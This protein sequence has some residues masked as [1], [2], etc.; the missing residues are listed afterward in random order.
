MKLMAGLHSPPR[1]LMD[2]LSRTGTLRLGIG[3]SVAVIRLLPLSVVDD[4]RGA[5]R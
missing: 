4:N 2:R 5:S 3:L 1:H